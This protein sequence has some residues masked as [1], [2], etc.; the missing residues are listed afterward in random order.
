MVF[1]LQ[2]N[3]K[4]ERVRMHKQ[5]QQISNDNSVC[6]ILLKCEV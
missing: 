2:I 6:P 5:L 3:E 1:W 4:R